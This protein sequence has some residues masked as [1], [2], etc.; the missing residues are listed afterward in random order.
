MP[1]A[2]EC[3]PRRRRGGEADGSNAGNTLD[4]GG[5]LGVETEVAAEYHFGLSAAGERGA[6]TQLA[7]APTVAAERAGEA[8]KG[9]AVLDLDLELQP[10]ALG[11]GLE[12]LQRAPR[13]PRR[14][15]AGA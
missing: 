3:K 4:A 5:E 9:F 12:Q 8:A 1:S 10:A 2:D 6:Q 7:L 15:L 14:L 11:E 13:H